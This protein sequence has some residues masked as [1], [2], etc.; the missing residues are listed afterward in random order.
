MRKIQYYDVFSFVYD[1]SESTYRQ[2]RIDAVEL[3]HLHAGQTVLD[4]PCGTGAN[5]PFLNAGVGENGQ[6]VGCDYSPG[7]LA[8]ARTR[9][10]KQRWDNVRLIETD[11]RLVTPERLGTPTIDAVICMLGFSVIPDWELVF[12]RTYDLLRP[13]GRY[14]AMDL[15]LEGTR[16]SRV[17]NA[18]YRMLASAHSTRHFWEPLERR[19]L[20][21]EVHDSPW[22]GGVARIVAGTKPLT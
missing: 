10:T 7:M 15:F 13:G 4:V 11:A 14:I 2:Q 1:W 3:L 12:E 18:Y 8:R 19:V 20:D 5:F 16:T 6:I 17:A 9:V 21:Y 22:F